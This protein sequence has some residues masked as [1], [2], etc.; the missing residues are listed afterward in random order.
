MKLIHITSAYRVHTIVPLVILWFS[1]QSLPLLTATEMGWIQSEWTTERRVR[2]RFCCHKFSLHTQRVGINL[3]KSCFP[4][5]SI[6]AFFF[7][8]DAPLKGM[9]GLRGGQSNKGTVSTFIIVLETQ[10]II[11]SL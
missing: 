5:D 2:L 7:G 9:T 1:V 3:T 8:V 11:Y 4:S 6:L 10:T